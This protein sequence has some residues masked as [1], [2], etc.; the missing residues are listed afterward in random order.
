MKVREAAKMLRGVGFVE[1]YHPRH[2]RFKHSDGRVVTLPKSKKRDI[3]GF[4]EQKIL[5]YR[6][7]QVTVH[8]RKDA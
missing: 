7:G 2:V 1:T 4:M 5:K 8:D 6:D 3:Y